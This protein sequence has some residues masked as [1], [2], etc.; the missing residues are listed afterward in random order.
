MKKYKLTEEGK[1]YLEKGL[2]ERNLIKLLISS[3]GKSVSLEEASKKINN[4]HIA[5]KWALQNGWVSKE[6]NRL[7]LVKSPELTEEEKSLEKIEK[8]KDVEENVLKI[9]VSRNLAV[10]ITETYERTKEE[11]A[12]AGNVIGELTHDMIRTGLWKG[13]KFK[14]VEV[15]IVRK[16]LDLKK[17][18]PE[19]RQPYNQFLMYVRNKLVQMGFK[20]MTGPTIETEFWNFDALFQPQNHPARDWTQTYSLKYPKFGDLPPK[21]IVEKV[22]MTHENGWKT[23]STGWGY[24]WSAKKASQLMPRAHD[25]AITPRYMAKGIEIP[26]RYFNIV[27]CYRPEVIDVTHGVEFYQTG[28]IVVAKDLTFKHLL[29]LLKQF[30]TEIAGIEKVK[31]FTDYYPFTEPSCQISGKHPELGWIELAGSG[32]FR[33]ELTEPLGIKDPVIAWGFGVERLAMN[34]LKINDIRELFSRNLQWLRN[35]KVVNIA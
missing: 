1:L 23:G 5:L 35:Q 19:K 22:R 17:T 21:N 25:T 14:P 8:G 10:K 27:R 32:I 12:K 18:V 30:A 16:K 24:K 26:G 28:G 33:P 29:G 6:E 9:L 34:A 7:K 20:E 11:I 2:P 3:P 31:F 15:E 4:F 13:K